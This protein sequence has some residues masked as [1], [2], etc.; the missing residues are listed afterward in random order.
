MRIFRIA[1]LALFCTLSALISNS[2]SVTV[3][4]PNGGEVLYACQQYPVQWSQS[5]NVSNYW[6]I[7]YS[8]DG[9]TIWAS[10]ATNYLSTNGQFLWTVPTIQSSTVLLRVYDAQ[11]S[12]TGDRSN[13]Y[14]TINIPVTLTSPDGG[15]IWQ[16]NTVHNITWNAAGTSNK[17]NIAYSID[18][19]TNWTNIVTNYSNTSGVYA[20]TVPTLPLSTNCKVRVQD[21]VQNC[22][23][24]ISDNVFTITPAQPILLT[25]NGGENLKAGCYF[26]ITWNTAT[27]YN[28]VRLDYSIDNGNNWILIINSTSNDGQY[29]WT[30]PTTPSTTGLVRISNYNDLS[31]TDISD[32]VFTIA[33]PVTVTTPNGGETLAG[34]ASVPIT[35]NKSNCYSSWKIDYT[36]D[37][38]TYNN[39][40]TLSD[41]GSVTQTYNW[42]VPNGINAPTAKI[43][44]SVN[45]TP[46]IFDESNNFFNII[47]SNDITL[48]TPNGGQVWQGL[49]QH[50]IT[51]T[52]LPTA[53]GQYSLQ[54]TTDNGVNWYSITT[55]VTG[56][57]YNWTVPNIPS[58]TCRIK[59][60]DYINSCKY[61]I[62]D[63][64]FSI[65]P[66][67]PV[68][69]TP[70]GGQSLYSG[71]SY[72]I[73]WNA[74]TLYSTVRLDYSIDNGASWV[75]IY[76]GTSNDGTQNWTVPNVSTT[77]ALVRISNTNDLSV[78][79][80]SD[81]VFTIKP[82][83]TIITPN[84]DEQVD[85]GGCTVTSITFDRSPAFSS[86]LIEYSLNNGGTWN[87]IVNNWT[88]TTNPA[89]YNWNVPNINSG[90]ALVR[91]TPS[92]TSYSDVSDNVF[93]IIKAVTIIQPN[94]G[95]IMQAGTTYD[96]AWTSD[97]ISNVYDLYYSINGG[98][99]F[100]NIV[101]GYVTSTNKYT[102]TVP[103]LPS[104]NCKILIV[105]NVNT[106][107]KD[108]SD[109]AFIISATAPPI[110]LVKPNGIADTVNTCSTYTIMWNESS[111]IGSYNIAY[112]LNGGSSWT[113]IISNYSTTT[114]SY[115]WAV[116]SGIA[117]NTVLLRVMSANNSSVFDL[118]DAYFV[119]KQPTYTFT[120]TGNWSN[121]A[122]WSNNQ[123]PP[124]NAPSCSE[125]VIDHQS[126]GNCI[127]DVQ[128]NVPTNATLRIK[129]GKRLTVPG[130]VQVQ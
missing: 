44:V 96:I 82:A 84:G 83:V 16:G 24:D 89:T 56:N 78:S 7:D 117:S 31:L 119:I 91:V 21:Y 37:G 120:G 2:Q 60:T 111:T 20:W 26:S 85:V 88:A 48:T 47:P 53:S 59:V 102:W 93:D 23:Q 99:T 69:L 90:Q 54:Y 104:S 130:D 35:W 92:S 52:N 109:Q 58:T 71:T 29:T 73:T 51:W 76:N 129:P 101:T 46:T 86:Y 127:L 72:T 13:A 62:S 11:N 3:I 33:P 77:T 123:V 87:T 14:F 100:T 122:N 66:A 106:C 25:P 95:G 55:N 108:T 61:D 30:L 63:N 57:S 32:A 17:Y 49:S 27:L 107:K 103:N 50:Q 41:N 6:N 36:L 105:D 1:T 40:T 18:G 34:C 112:S 80:V 98:S 70:N 28:S 39:I 15:E 12:A 79:D 68:L 43:R 124:T 125:I 4:Q 97:G 8:L 65:T 45:G 94:F 74:A 9:G 115:E 121:P 38:S 5:G 22:M 110:T 128:Q 116:P 42:A 10:V 126:G 114:H 19:G 64:V 118:S 75:T 67:Q 81:A 113:N